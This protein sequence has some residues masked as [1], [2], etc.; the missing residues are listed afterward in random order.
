MHSG[1][2]V[3]ASTGLKAIQCYSCGYAHLVPLPTQAEVDAYYNEDQFYATHA[4]PDWFKRERIEHQAGLW[5]SYYTWEARQFP[6]SC[7]IID[8][9]CGAGW[10]GNYLMQHGPYHLVY[11]VEPSASARAFSPSKYIYPTLHEAKN[12]MPGS[13]ADISVRM[14]LTLEHLLDPRQMLEE[15]HNLTGPQ[16]VLEVVV[17]HEFSPLQR[18]MRQSWGSD[19]FVQKPHINYFTGN[20][21]KRLLS[22]CGWQVYYEGATFPIELYWHLGQRYLGNDALGHK[23]HLRRLQLETGVGPHIFDIYARLYRWFG[24]GRELIMFARRNI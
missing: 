22:E 2:I 9:G 16:G 7:P 3:A 8:I 6:N 19:W 12:H 5:S 21:L 14:R 10:F 11:G 15:C 13:W 1:P 24:W 17:P 4:P 20:S 18:K 23:L